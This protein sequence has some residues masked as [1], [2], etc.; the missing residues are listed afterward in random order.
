MKN[1]ALLMIEFQNEWLNPTGKLYLRFKDAELRERAVKQAKA[2]LDYA[3]DNGVPVIYTAMGFSNDYRELGSSNFGLRG[4]IP[5]AKTWQNGG[6]LIHPDFMPRSQDYVI[7][8]K[9]GGSAFA[10]TE[11][12]FY[13]RTHHIE[14]LYIAGF[15]L[16]VCVL[17]TAWSAHDLG[18]EV[19][20]LEDAVA[21]FTQEQQDF[22]LTELCD[23]IG[24]HQPVSTFTQL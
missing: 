17:A 11:L 4:L 18:Y 13:L 21:A 24:Q 9:K 3:H 14:R 20:I 6:A 10:H 7:A 15:A 1:A 2:A 23:H 22:V 8:N 5:K 12:D 16:H 19:V